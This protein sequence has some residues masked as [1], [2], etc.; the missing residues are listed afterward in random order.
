MKRIHS[1]LAAAVVA[2]LSFNA[3]AGDLK[4]GATPVP[5]AEILEFAKPILAKE[6]VNLE[7][8]EFNDYVQPNLATDDGS[9]DANYF[10][11]KPYLDSFN[12]D[13]NLNLVSVAAIHI[14]PIGLYSKK[15][16]NI[17]QLKD[18]A[19]I[20]IPND[21]TNCGRALILLANKGLIKLKDINNVSSTVFDIVE[22]KKNLKFVELE[23][24]IL[25]RSISDVD[26]AVINTN[27]AIPANLNPLKDAIIL[28]GAD[29]PYANIIAT[30]EDNTQ[31]EYLQK[32][33]KFLQSQEAKD[34]INNKYNGAIVLVA[35]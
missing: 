32:L 34:F 30:R 10:Q 28:E 25:P 35:P 15:I 2:A 26:A 29:S 12:K 16:K 17:D 9:I 22:N 13:H 21:P 11:H 5:H 3:N 1:L 7:I 27:F 33:V 6:G 20:A 14:E 4:I 8:I 19:T 31:N 23:A 18:G 24:A